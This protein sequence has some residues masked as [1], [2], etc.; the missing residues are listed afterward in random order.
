MKAIATSIGAAVVALMV[1]LTPQVRAEPKDDIAI[2][3]K[4][5]V[6]AFAEHN[7]DRI[8]ALY[9]KDA[10]LW[11][12]NAPLLRT[13]PEE[14]RA[15]FQSAFRI[16]NIKVKFENQTIRMFG[17]VAVAA[18]NYTFTAGAGD[19]QQDSPARYSFTFVK[20]G[21]RWLIVDHNSSHMPSGRPST[22]RT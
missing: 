4:E 7:I 19:E 12:T 17:D 2:V 3:T 10:L 16:P 9:S 18:G 6:E 5:W 22:R 15:F 1:V 20:Q 14:V 13:T 21:D 8:L 11:G